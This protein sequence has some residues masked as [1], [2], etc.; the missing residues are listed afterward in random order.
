MSP[1]RGESRLQDVCVAVNLP[2][3][4]PPRRVGW[5]VRGRIHQ[6]SPLV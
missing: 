3:G 1:H 5:R 2:S 4:T 6:C